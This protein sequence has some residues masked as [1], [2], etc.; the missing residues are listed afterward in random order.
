M[1]L[2]QHNR[3]PLMRWCVFDDIDPI[4]LLIAYEQPLTI[5]GHKIKTGTPTHRTFQKGTDCV[6]C[7]IKG[8]F[9]A[10]ESVEPHLHYHLNLYAIDTEGNEVLMTSDH[11][12]PKS[13][14][15]RGHLTNRRPMCQ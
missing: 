1:I 13:K 11:T 14:G 2:A 4:L 8:S 10:V 12:I 15:G 6:K 3:K 7:G 9:F 5:N